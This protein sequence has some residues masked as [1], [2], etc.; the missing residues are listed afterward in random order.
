MCFWWLE[1]ALVG[2]GRATA[3]Q[4]LEGKREVTVEDSIVFAD[5]RGARR[6]GEDI[7]YSSVIHSHREVYAVATD[8]FFD[9]VLFQFVSRVGVHMSYTVHSECR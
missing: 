7:R 5:P 8:V 1:D 2:D 6:G 9:G 3:A 4:R